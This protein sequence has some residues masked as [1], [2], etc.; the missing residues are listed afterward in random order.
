[1]RTLLARF[2]RDESGATVIEYGLI[3]TCTDPNLSAHTRSS[4]WIA[5]PAGNRDYSAWVAISAAWYYTKS[6]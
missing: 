6:R 4:L 1:M 2:A 3:P 5:M